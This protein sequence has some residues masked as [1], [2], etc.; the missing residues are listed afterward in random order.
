MKMN[1][2]N[3]THC[4][5]DSAV[6]DAILTPSNPY[7]HQLRSRNMQMDFAPYGSPEY[8]SLNRRIAEMEQRV[9]LRRIADESIGSYRNALMNK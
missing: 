3:T 9:R 5:V 1:T 4:E 6:A 7:Y 8:Q 2:T